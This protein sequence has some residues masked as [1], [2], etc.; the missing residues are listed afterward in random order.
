MSN[1]FNI[2]HLGVEGG[3]TLEHR[4][5]GLTPLLTMVKNKTLLDLG[6]AEGLISHWLITKGNAKSVC[7]VEGKERLAKISDKLFKGL[8][9]EMILADL[10]NFEEI[11]L[12]K[13]DVVLALGIVQKL[14]R[15]EEFI[16][17]FSE[18]ALELF[19]IR[20]PHKYIEIK[21]VQKLLP[22]FKLLLI[23]LGYADIGWSG[24]FKR[25]N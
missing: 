24:I 6:S 8:N 20:V 1:W 13:Y 5:T 11:N 22:D 18:K 12:K 19:I 7:C 14:Y 2:P 23:N 9:Y 4:I 15:Q 3:R 21:E 25:I 10:N 17:Y 16:K